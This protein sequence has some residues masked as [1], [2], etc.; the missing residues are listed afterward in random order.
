MTSRTEWSFL[1]CVL[2]L[3]LY[4]V[5]ERA[6]NLQHRVVNRV[7]RRFPK[8]EKHIITAVCVLAILA[9]M[10]MVLF[11]W[12]IEIVE[13]GGW[14][15]ISG[16]ALWIIIIQSGLAIGRRFPK[17]ETHIMLTG[18]GLAVVAVIGMLLLLSRYYPEQ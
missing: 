3:T 8:Y 10:G 13:E 4:L 7:T 18:F 2:L 5:R 16:L 12:W 15:F 11:M 1:L 17:Y 6:I 9:F 14:I